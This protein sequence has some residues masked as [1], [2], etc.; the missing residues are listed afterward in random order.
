M[1]DSNGDLQVIAS[2]D[3]GCTLLTV[4][5]Q[6]DATD[7]GT[8]TGSGY[9]TKTVVGVSPVPTSV[10]VDSSGTFT[11]TANL[12]CINNSGPVA[13]TA[14]TDT[15]G[16]LPS[17][18]T[19]LD[20]LANDTG[21]APEVVVA[22]VSAVTQTGGGGTCG[23][24]TPTTAN[25]TYNGGTGT[26]TCTF[27][28][29]AQAYD[30]ATPF[31][32]ASTVAPPVTINQ[33]ANAAPTLT[34]SQPSGQTG[35]PL[36]SPV[37][38]TYNLADAD[39]VVTVA[40]SL[41]DD[42]NPLNG[43][44]GAIGTCTGLEVAENGD[45]GGTCVW[46]AGAAGAVG[47]NTYYVYGVTNDG[48]NPAVEFYSGSI[49]FSAT[50]PFSD[51]TENM[52]GNTERQQPVTMSQWTTG[53][54]SFN[55]WMAE[56]N[57]TTSNNSGPSTWTNQPYI[58]IEASNNSPGT[59]SGGDQLWVES[60]ALDASDYSFTLDFD[61]NTE[62]ANGDTI[63]EVYVDDGGGFVKHGATIFTGPTGGWVNTG[64]I[65]LSGYSSATMKIR[66][67]YTMGTGTMFNNDC[68]L[69]NIT[70]NGTP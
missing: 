67:Q 36:A 34:I 45:G 59:L 18:G 62:Y 61:Y 70:V 33:A 24:L 30:G 14:V 50:P 19:V 66:I 20:V 69:D 1:I 56:T 10:D 6:T 31:G 21:T 3:E 8:M 46:D 23:S 35:Q 47:G 37:D 9:C 11:P 52:A 65:N 16:A 7:R 43:F 41:D 53:S 51:W 29:Q 44:I 26:A 22:T 49:A 4:T 58:Y 17:V 63:L 25:I 13:A 12:A 55:N 64:S 32:A 60:P 2:N 57:A 28:Y 39:D 54:S 40:F 68:A 15:F 27:T 5:T 38:I 42:T 48:T